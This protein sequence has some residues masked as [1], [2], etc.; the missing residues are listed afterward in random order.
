MSS[1][2]EPV[3][4]YLY[5]LTHPPKSVEDNKLLY[6]RE[7]ILRTIFLA[8]SLLGIFTYIPSV[9]LALKSNLYQIVI[10]DTIAY[11]M[12]LFVTFFNRTSYNLRAVLAVTLFYLMGMTLILSPGAFAA[13]PMWLFAFAVLVGIILGARFAYIALALNVCTMAL[14]G[15]LL[16][17]GYLAWD[18]SETYTLEKWIVIASNFI[19]LN[20][21]TVIP[22]TMLV[23]RLKQS[24]D[25]ERQAAR[26]LRQKES[27]LVESNIRLKNMIVEL[28][29]AEEQ[30]YSLQT[31]LER[32]RRMESLGMLAGGVAHDLNNILGPLVG[33]SD[34]ILAGM[35]DKNPLKNKIARI[36]KSA[37]EA[38]DIIQDLLT[39]G[40][41]G[42]YEMKALNL[43]DVI[44]EYLESIAFQKLQVNRPEIKVIVDL[45]QDLP[46]IHGSKSHLYKVV[47]NIIINAFDAIQDTGDIE[48]KTTVENLAAL[49]GGY[50]RIEAG[51]YVIF[52]CKDGGVGIPED[53]IDKIF[54]P[55]YS[56]K[57]MGT[58][59]TGLGLSVV[60]GI[61]K[62]HK[63]YYDV[64]SHPGQGTEFILYFPATSDEDTDTTTV[65]SALYGSG[66]I[67]VI[68]DDPAQREMASE[69]LELLGYT[70][71]TAENGSKAVDILKKEDYDLLLMDMIMEKGFDGLD[72][73][74][75]IIKFKPGQKVVIV[76]GYSPTDRVLE[77]QKL[78]A[79]SYL[80]KPYMLEELA[81]AIK[82]ETGFP[83]REP[84]RA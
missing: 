30:K 35:D 63:G 27:K 39:L 22:G 59:G 45:E 21:L 19:L 20:T 78:G 83:A 14:I 13:G 40:R 9:I 4:K 10:V 5:N 8:A 56:K 52:S 17:A 76:S 6:W 11:G 44:R 67:L 46:L 74:R 84:L 23:N 60:Y 2:M 33:Y 47:M 15:Y 49:H 68:D 81:R 50:N 25:E 31:K 75:E 41:R 82:S 26:E 42:R 16:E 34:M 61:V 36:A 29:N 80:R 55:Y 62:D 18:V 77:M 24:L 69:M 28:K 70:V 51:Q 73:Y 48:I 66:R 12:A 54:E 64:D 79:G 1:A 43:N 38:V 53:E 65:S 3:K 72:T 58:S 57:K 7:R 37:G 32:A 71:T